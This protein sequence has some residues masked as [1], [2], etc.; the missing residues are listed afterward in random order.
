MHT[1]NDGDV[2]ENA[3]NISVDANTARPRLEVNGPGPGAQ[4]VAKMSISFAFG[5]DP[6]LEGEYCIVPV[7]QLSG[8]RLAW[9]W[10]N[11]EVSADELAVEL[12][13][14]KRIEVKQPFDDIGVALALSLP[15]VRRC[16]R[17]PRLSS[18]TSN[19]AALPPR[20]DSA[21]VTFPRSGAVCVATIP[22]R[23]V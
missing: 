6:G 5:F 12:C 10:G 3:A 15:A 19:R 21:S 2:V 23:F 20:R 8:Y 4:N 9:T 7:C 17:R 22:P 13:V 11:C 14:E 18:T 16:T 1:D